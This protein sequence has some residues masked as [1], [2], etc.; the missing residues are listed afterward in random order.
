MVDTFSIVVGVLSII[1]SIITVYLCQKI[2]LFNRLSK[3]WSAVTMAFVLIVFR[4]GIG[5]LR[6]FNVYPA[7]TETLRFSENILLLAISALYIVGFVAMLRNFENFDVVEKRT[8]E[9]LRHM[10]KRK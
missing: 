6:D 1:G 4:R 9:A 3:W 7:Y 2:Y 5:F 8:K 10:K